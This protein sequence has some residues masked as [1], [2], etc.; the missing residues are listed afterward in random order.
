MISGY[1]QNDFIDNNGNIT[2]LSSADIAKRI[3]V[4]RP[5]SESAI[6][7]EPERSHE[8]TSRKESIQT[9]TPTVRL[10]QSPIVVGSRI[11]PLVDSVEDPESFLKDPIRYSVEVHNMAVKFLKVS[12][13]YHR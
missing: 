12:L 2:S 6:L 3:T 9:E 1:D 11:P 10:F 7:T 4:F 8:K 13:F 5:K